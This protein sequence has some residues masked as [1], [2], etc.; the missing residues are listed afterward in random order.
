MNSLEHV[1]NHGEW[2]EHVRNVQHV[3]VA[4]DQNVIVHDV[5]LWSKKNA[6]YVVLVN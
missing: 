6:C 5:A 3:E 4:T 2:V 1:E